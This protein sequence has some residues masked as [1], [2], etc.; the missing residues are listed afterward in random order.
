MVR[1][2]FQSPL[3]QALGFRADDEDA[4]AVGSCGGVVDL[5]VGEIESRWDDWWFFGNERGGAMT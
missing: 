3:E 5:A 1:N 2:P 4:A